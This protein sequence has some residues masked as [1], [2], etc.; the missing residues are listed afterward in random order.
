MKKSIKSVARKAL[1][2]DKKIRAAVGDQKGNPS[3]TSPTVDS[4]VNFAQKMGVGADNAL[5]TASYGFNPITRNRTMLEWIHRGSWLGGVAIDLVAE[6]MT[7][8][9][10]EL[11]GS[12]TP[13]DIDKINESAVSLG[14][15]NAIKDTVAWSRLYGGAIGV[16]L[17]DG[18]DYKTPLRLETVGKNQFKGMLVLDRWTVD[19]SLNDLVTDPGPEMGCPKFY[20]VQNG[21]PALGGI[22]IHHSRCLRLV[23]I[24]LPYWQQVTENLWGISII[25]RI[26][27]RMVA[28]DSATTGAAQ[29]VYKAYIR[30]YKVKGLR[31]L[32][33]SGGDALSGLVQY[34]EMMRRFQGLEGITLLDG[35]DEMEQMQHSAFGGLSDSLMQFGQQLSGALQ[36]PLVRLF[37]QSPTGF[38]S[39]GESD[40][41]MYYDG[42]K[43][44]QEQNLRVPV[45]RVY[46]AL[47][48]SAGIRLPDGFKLEF[49]ALWQLTEEQRATVAS[50]TTDAITKAE[51]AGLI[52]QQGAMKELKQSAA[53]TG[54]FSN[55]TDEDIEAAE[56]SLPPAGEEAMGMVGGAALGEE[57]GEAKNKIGEE[58]EGDPKTPPAGQKAP[59][60]PKDKRRPRVHDSIGAVIGM[61]TFHDLDVVVENPKGSLRSGGVGDEAWTATMPQDYGYV[62]KTIGADGDQVDCHIASNYRSSDV[63]VI[64]QRDLKTYDFDEHKV[65]LGYDDMAKAIADFSAAY[66]DGLGMQRI[67][68]IKHMSMDEF[69]AWLGTMA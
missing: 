7:R 28:F 21:A 66:T 34:V 1:S 54:L 62:R 24:K 3:L 15:W 52:S 45:T 40:L 53:I 5:S 55:I 11:K 2:E 59:P 26:Y 49:K 19:P 65:M 23:G 61:K 68:A 57:A 9:G 63:W 30:T 60:K 10:V 44:Q 14:I 37:G 4:F 69:K 13:D 58:V 50:Q 47:A 48:Q 36:I 43:Q 20:M 41:R 8:A 38:N 17:I 12:V 29:L 16:M 18:Q 6:D 56:N 25:E 46:R 64:D 51:E 42:I 22:K 67:M 39:T 27:D 31:E 33:S 35:E 32:I